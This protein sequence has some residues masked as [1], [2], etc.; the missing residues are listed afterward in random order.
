MSQRLYQHNQL[1]LIETYSLYILNK[2][3]K[4]LVIR[5]LSSILPCNILYTLYNTL[6]HPYFS[7]CNIVWGSQL[8]SKLDELF[9]IQK[10]A[11]RII[12]KKNWNEHTSS[13]FKLTNILKLCDLNKYQ[14]ACFVYKC[15]HNNLPSRFCS[16]FVLNSEVHGYNT[17]MSSSL[18]RIQS[19]INVRHFTIKIHGAKIWNSIL[20]HSDSLKKNSIRFGSIHADESI[21]RFDSIRFDNLIKWTLVLC[22]SHDII[23]VNS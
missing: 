13:L 22:R 2:I 9:R 7:Y 15:I 3:N 8:T 23:F 12:T 4:N 5:K 21:F 20:E 10:K 14:V 19:R 1:R 18:H 6:I 11:I 16:Y 17:R